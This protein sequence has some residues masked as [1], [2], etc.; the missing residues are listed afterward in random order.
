[1]QIQLPVGL[2]GGTKSRGTPGDSPDQATACAQEQHGKSQGQAGLSAPPQ[3]RH[4]R[5]SGRG[6]DGGG[7]G[8]GFDDANDQNRRQTA[9]MNLRVAGA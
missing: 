7:D 2:D 8:D 9:A 3:D 4:Q 6:G 1:M 5:Q